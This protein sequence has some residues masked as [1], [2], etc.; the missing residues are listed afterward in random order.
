[1]DFSKIIGWVLLIAGLIL[2]LLTL[3]YSYNI[4]TAKS[5][6]PEFFEVPQE[7]ALTQEGD[8]LDIQA[9]IQQMMEEQLKGMIPPESVIQ[10][11]NLA[12]W[13]MLAFVLIFGGSQIGGLEVQFEL[14]FHS[15]ASKNILF[16]LEKV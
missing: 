13:S 9:Q 8:I 3:F 1:M 15:F 12:V 4:F 2:I 6:A 16:S 10:L 11:L 14:L 7:E 5:A